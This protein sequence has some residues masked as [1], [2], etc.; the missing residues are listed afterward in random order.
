MNKNIKTSE[1]VFRKDLYPR[2]QHNQEKAQEYAQNIGSL[3]PIEVNQHNELIDGFHRWTAHKLNGL[4]DISVI[5][6]Q[7]A[8]DNELLELAITRNNAHGLQMSQPD[9]KKIGIR[10][11]SAA[12]ME[13]RGAMKDRLPKLLSVSSSVFYAWVADIDSAEIEERNRAIL[14][15]HLRCHTQEEIAKAVGMKHT[16]ISRIL[17]EI[18]DLEKCT[19]LTE[20]A[21]GQVILPDDV[22]RAEFGGFA[23]PLYNVWSFGKKTNET[24]HFGNTEQRI[25]ENLLWLYT[26]PLDVVVDPFGGG[27]STLDVC[28]NRLRRCWI[29]DRKPKAGMEDKLRV[30]DVCEDLP[31]VPWKDVSLVY[32]D[33]PYWRQA[34]GQYSEDKADLANMPLDEF[35]E[36]MV[37]IVRRFSEKMDAGTIA[38]IIQ[39]TQWKAEPK[40]SFADHVFDIVKGVQKTKKLV[41][42][43]RVSCPYSTEQCTPQMVDWA[44]ENKKLLVLSRELIIW[45]VSK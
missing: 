23:M 19:K 2:I 40:G 7:T 9:K 28:A 33:P 18:L 34:A 21:K 13:E 44:K 3:P 38:L 30:L 20:K 41:L 22:A 31:S 17:C 45:K 1:V 32:L 43:N 35:T 42:E 15:M 14:E 11:Y 10:L 4:D 39:P 16:S 36:K 29:S 8:S 27:G 5:V 37:G 12:S 6:T 25:V 26:K 24:S